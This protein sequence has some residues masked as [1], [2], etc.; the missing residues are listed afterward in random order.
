MVLLVKKMN[1][2]VETDNGKTAT[3]N[4]NGEHPT[5]NGSK[6]DEAKTPTKKTAKAEKREL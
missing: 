1:P 2:E 3:E 5:E 4:T 6:N